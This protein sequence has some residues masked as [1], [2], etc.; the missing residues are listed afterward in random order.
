MEKR[1]ENFEFSSVFFWNFW[2]CFVLIIILIM[3]DRHN[4]LINIACDIQGE[5]YKRNCFTKN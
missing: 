1:G 5:E 2:F 3:R 4:Q